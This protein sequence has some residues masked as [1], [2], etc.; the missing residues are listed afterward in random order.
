MVSIALTGAA[1]LL[2][3]RLLALAP[4]A[5]AIFEGAI[6]LLLSLQGY[7]LLGY[8]LVLRLIHMFLSRSHRIDEEYE[9]TVTLLIPA[10]NEAAVLADKLT[11]SLQIDY[12]RQKL[13]ILVVSDGATDATEAIASRFADQ[14]IELLPLSPNRGK[15]T[16]LNEAFTMISS[17]IVVM[18]DANTMYHRTSIRKLVRHFVDPT[19]GAVSGKVIL[20]NDHLSYAAAEAQ[21]YGI[22]HSLQR[23]EG[24]TGSMIGA[25]GAMYALRRELYQYPPADTILDDFVISMDVVRQG[26]RLIH[27]PDALAFERNT[28]E[29]GGEFH[30]KVRVVAGGVQ[31]LL[32]GRIFPP[33]QDL[34]TWFKLV[35]HK[36]LRW[37]LGPMAVLM[38]V[39]MAFRL[40][41]PT[42]LSWPMA[43][44]AG[45]AAVLALLACFAAFAPQQIRRSRFIVLPNYLLVM[46]GASLVGCWRGLLGSQS[47]TWKQGED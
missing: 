28:A 5:D 38:V 41:M 32:R 23:L 27:D 43:V 46:C 31:T 22:E 29:M 16:A 36:I 21:Y 30:R 18:S 40:T 8:S 42:P 35:S 45:T 37:M 33:R 25:D 3:L 17:E 19:I 24:E 1:A 34:L 6:F 39:L 15:M 26:L 47:V 14:G 10:Y 12:P 2:L 20:L 11:N 7:A 44:F 13:R 9:P 4:R